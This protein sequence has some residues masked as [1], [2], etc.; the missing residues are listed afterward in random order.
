MSFSDSYVT[1]DDRDYVDV[2][3]GRS[4]SRGQFVD[5]GG[6]VAA[7]MGSDGTGMDGKSAVGSVYTMGPGPKII[8]EL[9]NVGVNVLSIE[10]SSDIISYLDAVAAE[11]LVG[12]Q[13]LLYTDSSGRTFNV[14]VSGGA[15]GLTATHN[16]SRATYSGLSVTIFLPF[17]ARV[18]AATASLT[19]SPEYQPLAAPSMALNPGFLFCVFGIILASETTQTWLGTNLDVRGCNSVG[20]HVWRS[21]MVADYP[22]Y[23]TLLCLALAW[24]AP[25]GT[26]TRDFLTA[27]GTGLGGCLLLASLG[28]RAWKKLGIPCIDKDAFFSPVL[29]YAMAVCAG[30]AFPFIG[31]RCVT[32]G[33]NENSDDYQFPNGGSRR[34]RQLVTISAIITAVI[35]AVTDLESVQELFG[36]AWQYQGAVNLSV[37]LWWILSTIASLAVCSRLDST[38]GESAQ[39]FL[40]RDE[41]SPVG[42]TVPSLP[43]LIMDPNFRGRPF[44]CCGA[45]SDVLCCI[46]VVGV[47]GLLI[48]QGVRQIGGEE[49]ATPWSFVGNN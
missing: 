21:S 37:G 8:D 14:V 13:C 44:G 31:L 43:R 22:R 32:G 11:R 46:V 48:W 15:E 30:F 10:S 42:W 24:F 5:E 49:D 25:F 34:A 40:T 17:C 23:V 9:R 16:S 26:S 12:E 1:D 28:S 33:C 47:G 29:A 4:R 35:Y 27:L 18:L 38:Q 2:S 3:H 6:M 39:P 20:S 45:I 36:F 41:T 7:N 19:L